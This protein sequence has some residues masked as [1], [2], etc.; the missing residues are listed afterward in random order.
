MTVVG[1]HAGIRGQS[2]PVSELRRL[3]SKVVGLT[4]KEG[5]M[6]PGV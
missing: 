4:G 2:N 3:P 1:V 6:R 5:Q